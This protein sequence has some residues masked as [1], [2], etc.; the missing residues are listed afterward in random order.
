ML[1]PQQVRELRA[2]TTEIASILANYNHELLKMGV[3]RQLADMLTIE[4]QRT[5]LPPTQA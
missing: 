5:L 1:T 2:A 4:L 3:D